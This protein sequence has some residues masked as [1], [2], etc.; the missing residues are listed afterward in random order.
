M[1]G[2]AT[3]RKRTQGLISLRELFESVKLKTVIDRCYSLEQTIDAHRYV[4]TGQKR[5]HVVI[6]LDQNVQ[7]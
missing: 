4:D 6:A 3:K 2:G 1:K 7:A 5:G